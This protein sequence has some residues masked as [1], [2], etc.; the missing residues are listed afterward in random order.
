MAG[1]RAIELRDLLWQRRSS[2]IVNCDVVV[3]VRQI[4]KHKTSDIFVLLNQPWTPPPPH[5]EP[6][7][8][9]PANETAQIGLS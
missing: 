3:Q 6:Y 1:A 5:M 7:Q 9:S 4:T 2:N 8:H